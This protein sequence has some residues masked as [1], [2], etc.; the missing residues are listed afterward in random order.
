MF[1]TIILIPAFA[2][3][4]YVSRLSPTFP[5]RIIADTSGS[6]YPEHHTDNALTSDH[7]QSASIIWEIP[8]CFANC[9][10]TET[11]LVFTRCQ[12]LLLHRS[13][14]CTHLSFSW[15]QIMICSIG[16]VL[17]RMKLCNMSDTRNKILIT[18]HSLNNKK[19]TQ[20]VVIVFPLL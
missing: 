16:T 9:Q 12:I 4:F 15:I 11:L 1:L 20:S 2:S 7:R 13:A 8:E 3:P 5:L 14:T 19:K 10:G 18:Q 6:G 17:N